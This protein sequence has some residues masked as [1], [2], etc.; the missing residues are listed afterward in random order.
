M[1]HLFAR[2]C[3]GLVLQRISR[4]SISEDTDFTPAV[5]LIPVAIKGLTLL[6]AKRGNCQKANHMSDRRSDYFS[7]ILIGVL[8][9]LAR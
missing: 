9:A 4:V 3:G 1:P 6:L 5:R 7:L 2:L 8:A